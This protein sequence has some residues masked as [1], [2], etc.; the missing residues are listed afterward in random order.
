MGLFIWRQQPQPIGD[1]A[2]SRKRVVLPHRES[3]FAAGREQP[4][5]LVDTA[6]DQVVD[7][8]TDV[9]RFATEDYR[10]A[11]L[12]PSGGIQAGDH[13]LTSRFLV[14]RCAVHLTSE[15]QTVHRA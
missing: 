4:I 3:E 1:L 5:R 14:A 9:A 8:H 13:A 7:E 2:E 11:F 12:Y 10:L 15:I 6:R